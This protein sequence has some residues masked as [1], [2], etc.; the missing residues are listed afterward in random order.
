M[1]QRLNLEI[2]DDG[3]A[4]ANC[5]YH[6]S[7]YTSSSLYL[8]G[9]ILA[10]P[11][12]KDKFLP[13]IPDKVNFAVMLLRETGAGTGDRNSGIISTTKEEMNETRRWQEARV[14]IDIGTQCVTFKNFDYLT[15][16]DIAELE[17]EIDTL[18]ELDMELEQCSFK[19]FAHYHSTI[20]SLITGYHYQVNTSQGVVRFIE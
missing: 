1:G 3:V 13:N 6:W 7:G 12:L 9:Q 2:L 16:E 11:L 10:S 4:L 14:E 15:D 18:P 17:L 8:T 5:Y 20:T 19:D